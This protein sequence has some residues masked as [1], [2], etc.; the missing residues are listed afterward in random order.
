MS[1]SILAAFLSLALSAGLLSEEPDQ[2]LSRYQERAQT[3][4]QGNQAILI[5]WAEAQAN[6]AAKPNT[7]KASIWTAAAGF[8]L[9]DTNPA[10]LTPARTLAAKCMESRLKRLFA[11][12]ND[13]WEAWAT[14]PTIDVR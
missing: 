12:G 11:G 9:S 5:K 2:A 8:C 6:A 4:L 14:A 3:V 1:P 13:G 7:V 10:L